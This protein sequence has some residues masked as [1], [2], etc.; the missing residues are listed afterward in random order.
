M[1]IICQS[2]S[3]KLSI[4]DDKLPKNVPSVTA[5][6]PKCQKPVEIKLQGE[7]SAAVVAAP[8]EAGE[9]LAGSKLAMA[10]F[11]DAQKLADAKAALESLGYK[12]LT[13]AKGPEA[14]AALRR[15]K[16]EV[17]LLHEGFAEGAVLKTI[18]P[19]AMAQRRHA[20]VLL[21]GKAFKTHDNMAAFAQSVNFVVAEQDLGNI[22][23]IIEQAVLD[24]DQFYRVFRESL[25]E[26]GRA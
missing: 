1:D 26:S 16:F 12:V 5:K 11:E 8:P 9:L 18:Q 21:V 10:C 23:T 4:P 7:A 19:M 20:C 22:K 6:C 24:N 15:G 17:L 13:P 25:H 3:T 2:C 14:V